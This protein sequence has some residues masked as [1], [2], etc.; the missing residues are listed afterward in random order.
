MSLK[1]P[2][3]PRLL[4]F[5]DE[6][7]H[8]SRSETASTHFVLTAVAFSETD[9]PKAAEL[10][11]DLKRD[12]GQRDKLH[13]QKASHHF[14][15]LRM[16]QLLGSAEWLTIASVVTCKTRLRPSGLDA[17]GAYNYA[18][19]FLLERLTWLAKSRDHELDCT[20]S[21]VRGGHLEERLGDYL[22]TLRKQREEGIEWDWV[23]AIDVRGQ[24]DDERLDLADIAA[25]GIA[26]AFEVDEFG[27]YETRYLRRMR[28][29]FYRK[30]QNL[31]SYGLKVFPH[32]DDADTHPWLPKLARAMGVDAPS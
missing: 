31:F 27:S 19:K 28:E 3:K 21:H 7:G 20:L 14:K 16:A 30:G 9:E 5:V 32:P 10:I 12:T 13:W 11:A 2:G 23:H 6:S 26:S 8:S 15:R 29:R 18:A 4:A 22:R 1:P 17:P 25:S 24:E